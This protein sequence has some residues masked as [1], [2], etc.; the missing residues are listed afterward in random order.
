LGIWDARIW[1]GVLVFVFRGDCGPTHFDKLALE[2]RPSDFYP[3]PMLRKDL[4]PPHAVT[5]AGSQNISSSPRGHWEISPSREGLEAWVTIR[6]PV[7]AFESQNEQQR[8]A[9]ILRRAL[10]LIDHALQAE[11]GPSPRVEIGAAFAW[12]DT[13]GDPGPAVEGMRWTMTADAQPS[14]GKSRS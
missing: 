6:L 5:E 12:P 11:A 9:E 4:L 13:P 3:F 14:T 2:R 7:A 8:R 10:R 1:D